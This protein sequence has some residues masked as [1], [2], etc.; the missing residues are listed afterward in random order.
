MVWE[1]VAAGLASGSLSATCAWAVVAAANRMATVMNAFIWVYPRRR[2]SWGS[3]D[4]WRSAECKEAGGS[5]RQLVA[6]PG[7]SGEV[8]RDAGRM[9]CT[10][11]CITSDTNT[12][13]AQPITL[14]QRKLSEDATNRITTSACAAI[15]P[16]KTGVAVT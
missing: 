11:A 5:R 7:E 9:A 13:A 4:E 3:S 12:T 14:Y 2:E 6:S 15:A 16:I 1:T 8:A 10:T